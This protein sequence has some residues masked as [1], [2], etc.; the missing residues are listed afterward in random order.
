MKVLKCFLIDLYHS[1]KFFNL[2]GI[3]FNSSIRK[4]AINCLSHMAEVIECFKIL[5]LMRESFKIK[6]KQ[7]VAK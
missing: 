2:Q 5:S 7:G 6:N 1:S 3:E 4:K